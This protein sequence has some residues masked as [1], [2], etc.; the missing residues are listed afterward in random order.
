MN[1]H[2]TTGGKQSEFLKWLNALHHRGSEVYGSAF[3]VNH[4]PKKMIRQ[5]Y[6][7]I[8][9]ST[10]IITLTGLDPAKGILLTRVPE[11]SNLLYLVKPFF[12]WLSN[13]PSGVRRRSVLWQPE[14]ARLLPTLLQQPFTALTGWVPEPGYTN[15]IQTANTLKTY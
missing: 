3:D 2:K 10:D 9:G 7:Y 12:L 1:A 15:P 4:Y 13:T 14:D 6:A 5:L 11:E 8:T